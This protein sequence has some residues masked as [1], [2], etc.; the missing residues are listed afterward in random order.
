MFKR[1]SGQSAIY[2][3]L[4]LSFFC[5]INSRLHD[6]FPKLQNE[7]LHFAGIK[8][9]THLQNYNLRTTED[10]AV[11]SFI[12]PGNCLNPDIDASSTDGNNGNS[13]S[14]KIVVQKGMVHDHVDWESRIADHRGKAQLLNFTGTCLIFYIIKI[15]D[16]LNT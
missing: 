1:K 5:Y 2:I 15:T 7:D 10:Q 12:L 9:K 16:R 11:S 4:L 13:L 8:L 6:N 3:L 14:N